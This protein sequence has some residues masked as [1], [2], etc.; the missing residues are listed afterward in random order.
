MEE[1]ANKKE[2]ANKIKTMENLEIEIVS[3]DNVSYH[4]AKKPATREFKTKVQVSDC[5][6]E[7][8]SYGSVIITRPGRITEIYP[9]KINII[10]YKNP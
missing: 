4:A 1:L 8:T 6:F 5:T 10:L 2:G 7:K 9:S 3:T